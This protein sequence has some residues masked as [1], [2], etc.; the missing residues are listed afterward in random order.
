VVDDNQFNLFLAEA[1]LDKLGCRVETA[2][3]GSR[4][5]E[6]VAE[7]EFALILMDCHMPVMDG[8]ATTRKIRQLKKAGNSESHLPIIALSADVQKNILD[9]CQNAG[10]DDYLSKPYNESELFATLQRWLKQ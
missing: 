2:D 4:A 8:F 5:L 3:N 7:R 9:L 6:L 1:L 10:M